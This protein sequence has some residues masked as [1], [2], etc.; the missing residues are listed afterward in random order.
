M[1]EG[2]KLKNFTFRKAHSREKSEGA[3]LLP[4]TET[5][6][7]AKGQFISSHNPEEIKGVT[8]RF[9]Q[10]PSHRDALF[11]SLFLYVLV[12]LSV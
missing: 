9:T 12:L 4:L 10:S 1:A 8:H 2:T 11:S 3:A 7:S 6:E 5:S